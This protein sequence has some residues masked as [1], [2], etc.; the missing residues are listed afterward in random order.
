MMS[1]WLLIVYLWTGRVEAYDQMY[2]SRQACEAAR[3]SMDIREGRAVCEEERH[4][5]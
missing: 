4:D 2:L 3:H 1:N 5:L